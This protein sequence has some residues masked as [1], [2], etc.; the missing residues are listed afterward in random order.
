MLVVLVQLIIITDTILSESRGR[1]GGCHNNACDPFPP[2]KKGRFL[3]V[4]VR[5]FIPMLHTVSYF[6]SFYLNLLFISIAFCKE[7]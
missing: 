7:I 6:F 3:I 4:T 5:L 2:P 1:G